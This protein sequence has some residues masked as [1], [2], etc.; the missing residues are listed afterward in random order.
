MPYKEQN[1]KIMYINKCS[2]HPKNI[3]KQIP[4]TINQRLNKRSSNEETF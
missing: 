3:A 1:A 2:S 4:K